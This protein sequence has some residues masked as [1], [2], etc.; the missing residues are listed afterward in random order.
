MP[1]RHRFADQSEGAAHLQYYAAY[2]DPNL[3]S[4]KLATR[5]LT[6]QS[7]P[8]IVAGMSG[9]ASALALLLAFIF[10]H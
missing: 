2:H 1:H 6:I 9:P 3:R 10:T 5:P 8:R 4:T 7:Q